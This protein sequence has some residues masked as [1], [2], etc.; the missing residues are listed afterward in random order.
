MNTKNDNQLSSNSPIQGNREHEKTICAISTPPGSGGIA[1][2][3]VSGYEA[4]GIC[5]KIFR[6]GKDNEKLADKSGYSV[7]Y[8]YITDKEKQEVD[9]V[10]VT[11]FRAPHSFTGEDVVEISCHGSVFIQQ[12]ILRLLIQKG[13]SLAKPGEFS[14][15]AFRNGKMDLSQAEAIADLMLRW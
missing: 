10:L 11:V 5:D 4:P 8:G 7:H 14:M 13:C 9:E 3:R 15:R 6:F 1:V 2:I 12:K